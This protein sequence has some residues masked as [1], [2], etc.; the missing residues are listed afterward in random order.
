MRRIR[1]LAALATV[2]TPLAACTLLTDLDGL[3][4]QPADVPRDAGVDGGALVAPDASPAEDA[5]GDATVE[6]ASP[7]YRETV[8]ADAP[9]GYFPLDDAANTFSVT[10][11]ASGKKVTIDGNVVLGVPGVSGTAAEGA[12]GVARFGDVL[13]FVGDQSWTFEAWVKPVVA[14]DTFYEFLNKRVGT[15]NGYVV[16]VRKPD[17]GTLPFVQVEQNW[18]SGARGTSARLPTV[19]RFVHVVFTF[20]ATVGVRAFLDGVPAAEGYDAPGGPTDSTQPLVLL[21]GYRGVIDE[22]AIYGRALSRERITAHYAAA[23]PP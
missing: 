22:I 18:A 5:S 12:G 10:D 14:A 15:S 21:G 1:A 7:T 4:A 6:A 2:V 8:L 11:V 23:K 3:A 9:L 19:D 13:D 20:D 16:Y 17:D